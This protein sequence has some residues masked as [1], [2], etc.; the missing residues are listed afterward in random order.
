MNLW[1]SYSIAIPLLIAFGWTA[2]A[3]EDPG[4]RCATAIA[5]TE[6]A[7]GI[8]RGLLAAIAQ[9]E[10]GRRNPTTGAATPWPWTINA[11]GKGYIFETAADAL[12]EVEALQTRGVRSIDVGCLQV[13]LMHHPNAFPTLDAAFDPGSNADY[14]G[15]FLGE[16]FSQTGDWSRAAA[17][18]HSS[19]PDIGAEYQRKVFAVWT[20]GGTQE[21]GPAPS[22]SRQLSAAWSA[23]L[24]PSPI[25]SMPAVGS[26]TALSRPRT[27]KIIPLQGGVS[28]G[29]SLDSYRSRPILLAIRVPASGN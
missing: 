9:V 18:Y 11:E 24:S 7:R 3:T 12:A 15:R 4:S 28:A 21:S 20:K 6:Q 13:N 25:A 5:L 16:L 23:T 14:A 29:R 17:A 2:R 27:M 22:V 26:L 1:L 19:T 10:S 8:P